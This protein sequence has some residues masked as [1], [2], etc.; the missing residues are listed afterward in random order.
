MNCEKFVC[1]FVQCAAGVDAN[2]SRVC[3]CARLCRLREG[4]HGQLH[5]LLWPDGLLRRKTSVK[6][7]TCASRPDAIQRAKSD[8]TFCSFR[9]CLGFA[10]KFRQFDFFRFHISAD[11]DGRADLRAEL[12]PASLIHSL[13]HP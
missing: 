11:G 4:G 3:V 8:F 1:H 13:K 12:F 5:R 6:S 2:Y 7:A 9:C 10:A